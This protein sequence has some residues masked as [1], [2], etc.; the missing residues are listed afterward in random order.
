[1]PTVRY[2]THRR[3]RAEALDPWQ[4]F[5][6]LHA[7][8]HLLESA[9]G[10]DWEEATEA[11]WEAHGG[12]LTSEW[13][14]RHPG[15]RPPLWWALDAPGERPIINPAPPDVE[16]RWR[17]EKTLF[18]VLHADILHGHGAPAGELVPW[19]EPEA[20]YLSRLGPLTDA[21]RPAA[22]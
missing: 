9:F 16:A 6:L 12:R 18:G 1:M 11:A 15:T 4:E 13:I 19:Q 5:V 20:S 21:E 7:V 2:R 10:P 17:G 3:Q 8:P 14:A 22:G